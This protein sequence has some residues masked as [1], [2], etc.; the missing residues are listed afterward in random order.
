MGHID[1]LIDEM[2]ENKI[3][4]PSASPY[5]SN[6][7]I[8]DKK[9]GDKRSVIDCRKL[10]KGTV[11]DS[12]PLPNVDELI[13]KCQGAK[14]FTQLDLAAGNWCVPI[15]EEDRHKTAFSVPR[16]NW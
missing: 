3:I 16:G 5:N 10:N 14:Y 2:L 9:N 13:D 8:V 6:V 7:I 1:R 4:E 12:Y 15:A 11:K